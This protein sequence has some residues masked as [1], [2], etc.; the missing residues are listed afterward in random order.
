MVQDC[1]RLALVADGTAALQSA[2]AESIHALK[3]P[4]MCLARCPPDY[5][6]TMPVPQRQQHKALSQFLLT[7]G[8]LLLSSLVAERAIQGQDGSGYL[9]SLVYCLQTNAKWMLEPPL[10]SLLEPSSIKASMERWLDALQ[11]ARRDVLLTGKR[12]A[13]LVGQRRQKRS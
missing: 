8:P 7:A 13:H 1:K 6:S 10:S 5:L 11:W 9:E 12:A 4:V 3:C 2:V